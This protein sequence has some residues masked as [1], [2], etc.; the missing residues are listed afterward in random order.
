MAWRKLMLP[1]GSFGRFARIGSGHS[2]SLV[3]PSTSTRHTL[4]LC[5]G[6]RTC[7]PTWGRLTDAAADAE[8]AASVD[9][10]SASIASD[11]GNILLWSGDF[12][13]AS[14][15]FARAQSLDFGHGAALLGSALVALE[16]EQDVGLQMALTQWAAV[17]GL[18]G[19][20]AAG[21]SRGMLA[22]RQTGARQTAPS[23]NLRSWARRVVCLPVSWRCSTRS[24]GMTMSRWSGSVPR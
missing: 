23:R 15:Q 24:S 18:P 9:P 7:W 4:L 11:Y 14:E 12:E 2:R 19:S 13:G 22:Y 10:L 20:L 16:Q 21:L 5:I 6:E 17:A 1:W 3:V 8:R